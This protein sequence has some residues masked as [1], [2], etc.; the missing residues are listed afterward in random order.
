MGPVGEAYRLNTMVGYIYK[1]I[2][3]NQGRASAAAIILF[4][5]IFAVTLVNLK[6]SAKKT[7]Y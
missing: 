2:E 7:Q 3:E 5:I 4:C 1:Y 6:V